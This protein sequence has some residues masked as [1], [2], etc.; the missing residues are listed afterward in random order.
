MKKLFQKICLLLTFTIGINPAIHSITLDEAKVWLQDRAD[1]TLE[2]VDDH[3]QEVAAGVSIAALYAVYKYLKHNGYTLK[4]VKNGIGRG[5]RMFFNGI[6]QVV[7]AT[8]RLAGRVTM[9]AFRILAENPALV[10]LFLQAYQ[11]NPA[12]HP[13]QNYN[14]PNQPAPQQNLPRQ[15][16]GICFDEK[17]GNEFTVLHC[18]HPYCTECLNGMVDMAIGQQSTNTL[19]CP[20]EGC[21]QRMN[22][23]DIRNICGQDNQKLN[24]YAEIAARER[25]MAM[26]NGRHCPTPNCNHAYAYNGQARNMRCPACRQRYCANCLLNHA[27]NIPCE[28]AMQN[29]IADN[30]NAAAN[31][32]WQRRN[33]KPCPRC[34]V[35]IQKNGGCNYMRCRQCRYEFCWRCL[36]HRRHHDPG[37]RCPLFG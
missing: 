6:Y 12:Y 25:L 3:P 16:C 8:G 23:A 30:A 21:R 15:E 2:F 29:N 33:T 28:Q 24:R 1:N 10:R 4:D 14:R 31:Q 13:P 5:F 37:H 27:N 32:E 35:R 7:A 11:N 34:N 22:D 19:V 26:P 36:Q 20:H 9:D 17:N 18:N